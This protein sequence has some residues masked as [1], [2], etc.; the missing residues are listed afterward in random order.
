MLIIRY[1]NILTARVRVA[2]LGLDFP[3]WPR[4]VPRSA[5]V[6]GEI[7]ADTVVNG[8]LQSALKHAGSL[9]VRV[10]HGHGVLL[11]RIVGKIMQP[12]WTIILPGSHLAERNSCL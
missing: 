11:R 10:E 12:V 3:I 2:S 8:V 4:I 9:I 5:S 6:D 1:V 7:V